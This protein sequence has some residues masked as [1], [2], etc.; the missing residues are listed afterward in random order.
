MQPT[1]DQ[2]GGFLIYDGNFVGFV[3]KHPPWRRNHTIM[4]RTRP[5]YRV[6]EIIHGPLDGGEPPGFAHELKRAMFGEVLSMGLPSMTGFL[7]ASLY[8]LINMFWLAKIGP[9]PVAAVTMCVTFIWVLSFPN[10]VVGTGSVAI[11]S[12]RFGEG[13][14]PRTEQA[15]KSTFLLKFGCGFLLGLL[16][17]LIL[18]TALRIMG[19]SPEVQHQGLIY[20]GVQLGILGFAMTGYSVYTALRSIGKPREALWIQV[21][22]TVINCILDP[23]LIFGWGPFPELGILGASIAT[24]CA[25]TSVVIMGC[26]V[27]ER[28][29]C[30]V[31]VR[32]FRAP[33]PALFEMRQMFRIGF[34]AGINA[35]SFSLAMSLAVKFVANYGTVMVALYGMSTKVLHFG[36]MAVVGLGLG[37]G[38]LIGQFLGSRE[39]H[40]AWLAGVLSIRLAFWIMVGFTGVLLLGAPLIVRM[41]FSDPSMQ[42]PGVTILRIVAL[43]LPFI[44]LHIGAETA[45]EGAGQNMPPMILSLVHSWFMVVPFM[46]IMGTVLEWGPY[47][48]MA[49]Y[50]LAH[51]IGGIAALWLFRRGSWLK[52]EV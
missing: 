10:M 45:F 32:W 22:S 31:R 47:A 25:H 16:G 37:T 46:Y 24:A 49:G 7:V 1:A 2:G 39:L 29:K 13:D 19:A 42:E 41:F 6:A 43:S 26:L 23:L 44:G 17:M 21:I 9:A 51:V 48:V 35:L 18:P 34:P 5:P 15:I 4:L 50:A 38:A 12:R 30:P 33:Q 8:E 11:I 14:L 40:K 3:L 36:V 28:P 27:L 52:H 20:G